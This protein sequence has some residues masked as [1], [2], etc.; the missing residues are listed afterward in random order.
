VFYAVLYPDF[1][2]TGQILAN[3]RDGWRPMAVARTM[4]LLLPPL[5]AAL[6]GAPAASP[7]PPPLPV[8]RADSFG[9]ASLPATYGSAYLSNGVIGLR[10]GPNPLLQNSTQGM[11]AGGNALVGGFNWRTAAGQTP[12]PAVYPLETAVRVDGVSMAAHPEL[13]RVVAQR[14]D[15]ASGELSTELVFCRPGAF[16]ASL[17]VVAFL[18]RA[19]P[20]VVAMEISVTAL[21]PPHARVEIRPALSEPDLGPSAQQWDPPR[22]L[23]TI[24]SWRNRTQPWPWQQGI[25]GVE[26]LLALE[27]GGSRPV[28]SHAVAVHVS[29]VNQSDTAAGGQLKVYRVCAGMVSSQYDADP[30]DSAI[31]AA[32][33]ANVRVGF[34][35]VRA[36]NA[37]AWKALWKGRVVISG[38]GVTAADQR[39]VDLAYY[40]LHSSVHSST[41]VGS[42]CY[43]LSQWSPLG[44]HL[45]WDMDVWQMPVVALSSPRAGRALASYRTGTLQSA[46][47]IAAQYGYDGAYYPLQSVSPGG[48]EGTIDA[49]NQGGTSEEHT[50]L[51]VAIGLWEVVN[52]CGD[53]D[54]GRSE[55][56]PVLRD[57]ARW[58]CS[59]G[60]WR[61]VDNGSL[62]PVFS[63]LNTGGP[64]EETSGESDNSYTQL[65]AV[66]TME[67]ALAAAARYRTLRTRSSEYQRWERVRDGL[68]LHIADGHGLPPTLLP[69][70]GSPS[71]KGAGRDVDGKVCNR[72]TYQMGSVQYL[73]SHGLPQRL[74]MTIARNTWA[75]E[76][77]LRVSNPSCN[78]SGPACEWCSGAVPTTP[79]SPGFTLPPFV[80]AAAFFGRR[81][82]ALQLWR[83]IGAH[84]LMGP[85]ELFTEYRVEKPWKFATYLTTAGSVLQTVL[86]GLCGLR[87]DANN[88]VGDVDELQAGDFTPFAASLPEGW[89]AVSVGQLTLA[90]VEYSM[91]ARHGERA[92][93]TPLPVDSQCNE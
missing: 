86:F 90:G 50:G 93:L 88:A 83:L 18:S 75:L 82:T 45:F 47:D 56:W 34:E 24:G 6:A 42:A 23:D 43:T 17:S 32:L 9:P 30:T 1:S 63:I 36:E 14:L 13:V 37:A 65:A 72:T 2:H 46:R 64:D 69:S 52:L 71:C 55:V 77:S 40:Y 44:G 38:T 27:H 33:A 70:E 54:F 62:E 29:R 53:D 21:S 51:D 61:H 87:A 74:N 15:T 22:V 5:A 48:Y 49:A 84:Y 28:S 57:V 10:V 91:V 58:V 59:R 4:L 80:N 66:K 76:E 19:M 12:A 73:L 68:A 16:N 78:V 20:V 67:A 39:L 81:D 35:R 60:V 25:E 31:R 8:L 41:R 3:C 11:L 79:L 26:A 89:E 92:E 7:P 85:W